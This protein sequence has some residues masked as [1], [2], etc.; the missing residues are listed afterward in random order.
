MSAA[1]TAEARTEAGLPRLALAGVHGFGAHHLAHVRTLVDAGRVELVAVC[2]R[3]PADPGQLPDGVQ[4]FE[5]LADLL[6]EVSVDV[7]IVAT[8]IPTHLPLAELALRAGADVL[9]EKPPVTSL[10]QLDQLEATLAE[11][12]R[13]CQVGFQSLGSEAIGALRTLVADG[14]LGTV[15]GVSGVGRWV[16]DF[17]YWQRSPWAGHREIDGVPVMDGVVSNPLAHA[18]A[19]ALALAGAERRDQ[20]ASA[21]VDL[22]HANAIEA[23]DT[24]VVQ[25]VTDAGVPVTLG[26]TLCAEENHAPYVEITGDRGRARFHYTEDVVEIWRDGTE[27]PSSTAVPERRTYGR[28]PLLDNLL[29]YRATGE[30]LLCPLVAT[31]AFMRVMDA[32]SATTP[33]PVDATWI[34]E[35]TDGPAPRLVVRD[36]EEWVLRAAYEHRTFTELHAPFLGDAGHKSD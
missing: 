5:D 25:V 9:L 4:E 32:V 21:V 20:V 24:S 23:D 14:E 10:A 11:T 15:T 1:P 18:T 3:R 33:R 22:F 31:G 13:V 36:V 26:L 6:A 17:A 29:A 12:G 28:R 30:P 7:V 34:D 27:A 35:Q 2:D 8:P 19:T 16:R